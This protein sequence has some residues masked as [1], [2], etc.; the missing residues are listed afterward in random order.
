[1]D[2][3]IRN[4][5]SQLVWIFFGMV[6]PNTEQDYDFDSKYLNATTIDV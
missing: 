1:M 6:R 4:D 5:K 3:R 2:Q